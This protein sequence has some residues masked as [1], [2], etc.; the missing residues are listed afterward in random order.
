MYVELRIEMDTNIRNAA[1]NPVKPFRPSVRMKQREDRSN[2]SHEIWS[3][4]FENSQ[5]THT[6]YG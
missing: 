5:L 1:E 6:T 2:N 4:Y 3:W